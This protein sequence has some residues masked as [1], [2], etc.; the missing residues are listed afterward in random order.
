MTKS[1]LLIG[2]LC[3]TA[4]SF[5]IAQT[6]RVS[7]EPA[8]T[9]LRAGNSGNRLTQLR[10]DTSLVLVPVLVTDHADRVVTGLDKGDF[11]VYDDNVEQ[12]ISHFFLEDAPVSVV[13]VFDTSS[14]MGRKLQMS[15]IAVGEFLKVSNPAD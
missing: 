12:Q 7:I 8:A 4:V 2:T 10:V 13:L 1:K 5:L 11:K 3:G 15:R 9:Q 6:P 14:S